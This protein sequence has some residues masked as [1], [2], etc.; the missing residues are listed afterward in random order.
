VP[1]PTKTPAQLTVPLIRS[2]RN[3]TTLNAHMPAPSTEI[4]NTWLMRLHNLN[5]LKRYLSSPDNSEDDPTIFV[6]HNVAL[7]SEGIS[8]TLRC[9]W[10]LGSL[11]DES[12]NQ[13]K[14]WR[15]H[16]GLRGNLGK[17]VGVILAKGSF[18]DMNHVSRPGS[19]VFSS[20]GSQIPAILH[21]E[22]LLVCL[23]R[24]FKFQTHVWL[25]V[26]STESLEIT[27][28]TPQGVSRCSM[29]QGTCESMI[30]AAKLRPAQVVK[31]CV[32]H[33]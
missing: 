27:C 3:G 26:A 15:G 9:G 11:P 32:E 14:I 22:H 16:G 23:L 2:D 5:R 31:V 19:E 24:R 12:L 10:Q 17:Q 18:H 33:I 1:T 13:S 20:T 4:S 28:S 25:E 8:I 29:V 30:S 6:D 7:S 21:F